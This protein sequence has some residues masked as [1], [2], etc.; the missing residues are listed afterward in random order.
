MPGRNPIRAARYRGLAE[1]ESDRGKS[2]ILL[3]L[4]EEADRGVLCTSTRITRIH[5][6]HSE[7]AKSRPSLFG[8]G[9]GRVFAA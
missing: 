3:R 8:L 4:A 5:L 7:A 1:S 9:E 6:A 2:E